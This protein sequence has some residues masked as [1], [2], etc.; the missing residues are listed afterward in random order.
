MLTGTEPALR[1]QA[2]VSSVGQLAED[3]GVVEVIGIGGIPWAVPH[4]RPIP[5][6]TTASSRDRIPDD[7][8]HP[9][10]VIRVPAA[11]S[12]AIEVELTGMGIP[13]M[14]FWA[15]VPQ[16]VGVEFYPAALALLE[17]IDRHL[18]LDL[19]FSELASESDAQRV[20][21]DAITEA[22]PDIA[23]MVERL[24]EI[25]DG[26]EPASGEELASEIERFLRSQPDDEGISE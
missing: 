2:F 21:L 17:R 20:H 7:D 15:R 11:V 5:V 13:A 10:G 6:L 16:Y 9:D 22:R 25:V 8:E 24:E 23:T 4:T 12:R 1:W 3:F 14:G 26:A 18:G 19:D